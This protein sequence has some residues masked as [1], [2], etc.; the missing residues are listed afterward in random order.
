[1]ITDSEHPEPGRRKAIEHAGTL[2]AASALGFPSIILAR[3]TQ[4]PVRVFGI[5][6]SLQEPLRQRAETPQWNSLVGAT[7]Q[8]SRT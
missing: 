4:P 8:Y 2:R 6:V 3:N 5:H 7:A 1:M